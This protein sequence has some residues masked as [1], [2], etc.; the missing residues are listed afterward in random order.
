[1]R[2]STPRRVALL[3]FLAAALL[4]SGLNAPGRAQPKDKVDPDHVAKVVKGT[5][6]FKSSVRGILQAKCVKCHSGE[7]IEGEFDMNTRESLVKGG[8]RGTAVVPGDH[9]KSLLYQMTAHQKE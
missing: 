2:L 4:V 8:G 9:K 1:M 5:D 3:A 6:L 7:K